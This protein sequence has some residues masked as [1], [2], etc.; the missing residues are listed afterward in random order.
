MALPIQ[1]KELGL[2][3][4]L[5]AVWG[6]VEGDVTHD[7][8][9]APAGIFLQSHPLAVEGLLEETVKINLLRLR[10]RGVLRPLPER[11][12]IP[13]VEGGEGAVILQPG[14]VWGVRLE[15]G[16]L[17]AFPGL[18]QQGDTGLGQMVVIHP[19][20]VG[21]AGPVQLLGGEE[22]LGRQFIQ[23]DEIGVAGKS[24]GG[25]IGG[26]AVPRWD[27]GQDLPVVLPGLGEKIHEPPG[28][29]AQGAD[30][31]GAG[32]RG[33]GQQDAAGTMIFHETMPPKREY[34][35]PRW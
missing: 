14:Q 19:V 30:A 31:V 17:G 34:G 6:E 29:S 10:R 5:N 9:A 7:A 4:H 32:Q 15:V 27:K 24:G 22:P 1:L 20:R 18:P 26:G 2:A 35:K 3:P 8:D 16:G 11:G 12:L 13:V 28:G 33:H 23:V 21:P 25:H